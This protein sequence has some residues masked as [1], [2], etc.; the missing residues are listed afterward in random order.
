MP[1]RISLL[2][3]TAS[4]KT[5]ESI[6]SAVPADRFAP[7]HT[8]PCAGEAKREMLARPCD[9]VVIDA[10]LPD[11]SGIRL[12][13]DL[14]ECDVAGIL[15]LVKPEQ[16]DAA[17]EKAFECGVMVL[18]TPLNPGALNQVLGLLAAA[19]VKL[20]K[21]ADRAETLQAKMDEIRLV[22]RAKLLLVEKLR[23]T[24]AEAHRFI[25]KS[26]MDRCEKRCQIAENIIRTYDN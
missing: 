16:Y 22:N 18:P 24:E 21:M 26:A 7:I 9:I 20:R 12:A 25:E 3:V 14:S 8:A 5:A 11:D 19:A 4:Q 6:T 10:P 15:L 1:R 2:L 17:F 23:M 13:T